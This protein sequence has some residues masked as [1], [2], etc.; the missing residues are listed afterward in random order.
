MLYMQK[1]VVFGETMVEF[2]QTSPGTFIKS[3]SGDV[4]SVAVYFQRAAA[5]KGQAYL[6]TGIGND[7]NSEQLH[8]VIRHQKIKDDFLLHHPEKKIGL[9]VINTD[10]DG[11]RSFDYW[12]DNSAARDTLSLLSED[13]QARLISQRPEYFF[14]SGISIAITRD[15]DRDTL[16]RLLLKLKDNGTKVVFDPNYRQALWPDIVELKACYERAFALCDIA[17]PSLEDIQDIYAVDD[18]VQAHDLIH[19]YSGPKEV[20]L[21]NGSKGVTYSNGAQF[22]RYTPTP[23]APDKIQD[24]TAAGDSFNGS[25]LAAR[26][27]GMGPMESVTFACSVAALVIQHKGALIPESIYTMNIQQPHLLSTSPQDQQER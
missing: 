23:I 2:S 13:R 17:L 8:S 26:V 6:L 7:A 12:R 9:Y 3:F 11:E 18:E 19:S 27:R 22:L 20:V 24:T 15:N 10:Y 1:L 16:W 4:H 5:K 14:F 25:Y 21:T